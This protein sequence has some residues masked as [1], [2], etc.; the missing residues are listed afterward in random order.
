MAR[1]QSTELHQSVLN[2]SQHALCLLPGS[3]YCTVAAVVLW[4]MPAQVIQDRLDATV[5]FGQAMSGQ[6]YA[7]D[8]PFPASFLKCQLQAPYPSGPQI[9]RLSTLQ[10]QSPLL[11]QA[12]G[13]LAAALHTAAAAWPICGDTSC[14]HRK[15][16]CEWR[17]TP[18]PYAC[19]KY[20]QLA[21]LQ[22]DLVATPCRWWPCGIGTVTEGSTTATAS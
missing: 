6:Q 14:C 22:Q 2:P 5:R 8:A 13:Y 19:T 12:L 20:H 15:C 16:C 17:S 1:K 9:E 7:I 18:A 21:L 10:D 3:L 4:H 11:H